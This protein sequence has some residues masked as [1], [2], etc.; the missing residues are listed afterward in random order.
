MQGIKSRLV[1][2]L[3]AALAILGGLAFFLM[4]TSRLLRPE[5]A[6]IELATLPL[7][8]FN[9]GFV[10]SDTLVAGPALLVGGILLLARKPWIGRLG[11]LL[12]F[13]GFAINLYA[14]I[15]LWIGL[16]AI[17]QPMRGAEL[18]NIAVLTFLGVLCMIYLGIQ[19]ARGGPESA[20]Q[21]PRFGENK[22]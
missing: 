15:F 8:R 13:T 1:V 9:W 6:E 22:G 12:A 18:W 21:I 5:S 16:A 4:Q 10:W 19:L 3:I 7:G 2:Y 17:G 11:Q 14:M 20:C